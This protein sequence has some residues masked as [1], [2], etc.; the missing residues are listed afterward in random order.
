MT[1]DRFS[2]PFGTEATKLL[3]PA[4]KRRATVGLSLRDNN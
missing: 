1:G 4:L 2:R 3:L